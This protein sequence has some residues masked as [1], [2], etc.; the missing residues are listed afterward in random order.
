MTVARESVRTE[1]GALEHRSQ[2]VVSRCGQVD[3]NRLDTGQLTHGASRGVAEG[4]RVE[5][6]RESDH[7]EGGT[8]VDPGQ[9]DQLVAATAESDPAE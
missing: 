9:P 7:G 3:G 6:F 1:C 8:P 4:I 2:L 5:L